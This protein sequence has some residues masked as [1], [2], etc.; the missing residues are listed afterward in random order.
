MFLFHPG[1]WGTPMLQ[2]KASWSSHSDSALPVTPSPISITLF[3]H[4]DTASDGAT[5]FLHCNFSSALFLF[6]YDAFAMVSPT[7]R[8]H[9]LQWLHNLHVPLSLGS[10]SGVAS[11]YSHLKHKGR[12]FDYCENCSPILEYVHFGSYTQIHITSC[13]L[14]ILTAF[15]VWWQAGTVQCSC[16]LY[17]CFKIVLIGDR[18][19]V[20]VPC[21]AMLFLVIMRVH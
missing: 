4:T 13:S 17:C 2:T 3:V 11:F 15:A 5:F 10:S 21:S 8:H 12:N 1:G 20:A 16:H 19:S 18:K 14:K 6:T 7:P 9:F